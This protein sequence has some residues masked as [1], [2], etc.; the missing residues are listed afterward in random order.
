MI[1]SDCYLDRLYNHLG[2]KL[3]GLPMPMRDY[4]D[5]ASLDMSIKMIMSIMLIEVGRSTLIV[6]TDIHWAMILGCIKKAE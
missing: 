5:W 6:G 3:P 4:L 1:N 2:D